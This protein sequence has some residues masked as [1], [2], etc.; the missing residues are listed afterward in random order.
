VLDPGAVAADRGSVGISNQ[1]GVTVGVTL[2]VVCVVLLMAL[3]VVLAVRRRRRAAQ[4]PPVY[5]L[6]AVP[7]AEANVD[8]PIVSFTNVMFQR[9]L[10][11]TKFEP[12]TISLRNVKPSLPPTPPPQ[13]RRRQVHS[14]VVRA[15]PD[16]SNV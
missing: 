13:S 2:S 11:K 1:V 16:S 3:V 12:H 14:L 6:S 15:P 10:S 4:L 8:E 9:Q 5:T 7:V